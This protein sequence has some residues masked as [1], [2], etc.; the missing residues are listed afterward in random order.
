MNRFPTDSPADLRLP[1]DVLVGSPARQLLARLAVGLAIIVFVAALT[2]FGRD[3][4]NDTSDGRVDLLD[5]FYYAT[6]SVSTTGYGDV[7]P[8]S[9][10][11]RLVTT[12]VVTPARITFL[13][14]LVGTSIELIT[15]AT[16]R[17]VRRASWRRR[18][19]DHIVICGFGV[20]GRAALESLHQQG[21][22]GDRVVIV[23]SSAAACDAAAR[24][25]NVAVVGDM[26]R[27]AVL[28]EAGVAR[29][30]RVIV[31]PST[32]DTAVLTVLTV[33]ALN[34]AASI[35]ASAREEENA[36]LL[37]QSGANVVLTSAGSIGRMLG[38]A[39]SSQH[40]VAFIEDLLE[41]GSGFDIAE[42]E[43]GPGEAGPLRE[44]ALPH[45]LVLTIYRDGAI[46]ATA[47]GGDEVVEV[48]DQVVSL[49]RS[50]V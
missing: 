16:R 43:V 33:R 38:I 1:S 35:V 4:Y 39:S 5:A 37:R 40:A 23:D 46:V 48:G 47:P 14:L 25:G 31:V 2:W 10:E 15:A 29:A 19:N 18:L 6:V 32:D 41:V 20:K 28:I 30:S 22:A 50:E 45:E 11:S 49:T 42:R 24:L 34:G 7:V 36:P 21:V 13:I 3:G 12:L 8:V 9:D 27:N 44:R 26:T 17:R